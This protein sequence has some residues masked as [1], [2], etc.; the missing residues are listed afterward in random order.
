MYEAASE[1][2]LIFTPIANIATIMIIRKI[3]AR[4]V[5]KIDKTNS[6]IFNPD[7]IETTKND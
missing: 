6:K 4:M 3:N 7:G 2:F 1:S 5:E